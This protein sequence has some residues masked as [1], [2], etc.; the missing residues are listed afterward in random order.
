MRF[1]NPAGLWLG[2]LAIPVVLLH[3]LRPK[4]PPVEV[5][6]TF[7]WRP[8]ARPV[9]VAAPWQRLRPSALLAVQL[10]AVALLAAAAAQPVR[11]TGAL[12]AEHTVFLL[13]ASGSMAALDGSPDRLDAARDRA[14]ALRRQVPGGGLASLVVVDSQPRVVLSASPDPDAFAEALAA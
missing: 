14:R 4:R 9:S 2:L 1:S 8:V 10:L 5:S 12:L 11:A 7:L 6:S 13:D 3:V